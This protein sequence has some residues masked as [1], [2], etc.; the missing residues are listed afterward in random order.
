MSNIEELMIEHDEK[1]DI[2]INE[3][4]FYLENASKPHSGIG[5]LESLR[6]LTCLYELR[7]FSGELVLTLKDYSYSSA[8]NFAQNWIKDLPKELSTLAETFRNTKDNKT[9]QE[10]ADLYQK[11]VNLLIETT[12]WDKMPPLENQL[13]QNWMPF[14]FYDYWENRVAN[15]PKN[16]TMSQ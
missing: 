3:H 2:W 14:E 7:T 1:V 11:K 6:Q 16:V 8:L 15:Q 12:K 9:K 10:I 13:P 4:R 5:E